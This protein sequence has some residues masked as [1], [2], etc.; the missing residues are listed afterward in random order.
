MGIGAPSHPPVFVLWCCH[1]TDPAGLAG[2][3]AGDGC[4]D[5]P[6]QL[7]TIAGAQPGAAAARRERR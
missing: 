5:S 1:L 3:V 7:A 6:A 2:A 4:G